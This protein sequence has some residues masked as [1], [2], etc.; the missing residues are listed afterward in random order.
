MRTLLLGNTQISI[1]NIGDIVFKL[2]DTENVP[3]SEWRPKHSDLFEKDLLFP[4]QNVLFSSSESVLVDACDY[5]AFTNTPYYQPNYKPPPGLLEQLATVGITPEAI[6][7][8]IITHA[9]FDHYS[10]I[11]KKTE[12]NYVPAF[13]NAR[14]Y[15]GKADWEDPKIQKELENPDSFDSHTLGV[16]EKLGMLEV[17]RSVK[18][19]TKEIEIVPS[20]GESPGHQIVRFHSHNGRILYCLGDLFHH[21]VEI[22]N[23]SW[24]APWAD[25]ESNLKSRKELTRTALDE[26]ALLLASHMALGKLERK[27]SLISFVEM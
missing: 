5:E 6:K 21:A 25:P 3:E 19:I 15:L 26:D 10:G 16:I 17:V 18:S 22:E 9:H 14:Y 13:P 24:M 20:P 11:T 2:K 7:H 12:T 8:V 1:L 4:T 27:G 23:L